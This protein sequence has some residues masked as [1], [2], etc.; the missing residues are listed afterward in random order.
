M[1]NEKTRDSEQVMTGTTSSSPTNSSLITHPSILTAFWVLVIQSAQRHWRVRQMGWVSVGLLTMVV[2]IVALVTARGGWDLKQRRPYRDAPTFRQFAEQ[3]RLPYQFALNAG[4]APADLGISSLV[5]TT[6]Q[7]LLTS[8]KLMHNWA[9]VNFTR[10][11]MLGAYLGFV[12]P[13]FTLAYASAAFGTERESR[14]LVWLM[15]RPIPRSGIYLAKFLGTLPW[16][17]AFSL[18]GFLAICAAGGPL[19]EAAMRMYWPAAIAATIAFAALFH[20]IGA[21]FR[22]PVVVGLVYVFFFEALVAVLPGSLKLLSIGFYSRCLMYNA[23]T[24][25]GYPTEMLDMIQPV[26]NSTAWWVLGF[27]TIG[28][29]ALGMWLFA[30]SEYRDDV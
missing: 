18:G 1:S 19:G 29:T 9:F 23:A 26:S 11:A 2:V 20:L 14:S 10:W 17:V 30:R 12:L 24:A 4:F 8:E 7:H 15:T 28:L 21:L 5:L 22:R 6:Q 16:C 25:A 3:K 13:L 27:V